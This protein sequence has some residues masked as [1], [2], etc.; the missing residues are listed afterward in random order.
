L[1]GFPNYAKSLGRFGK[2]RKCFSL[3]QN[4][5]TLEK[6]LRTFFRMLENLWAVWGFDSARS[7]QADI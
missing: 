6:I 7:F 1:R 2:L 5:D 3:L 4:M